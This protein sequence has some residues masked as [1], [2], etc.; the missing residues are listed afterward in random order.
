[1]EIELLTQT[2][3]SVTVEYTYDPGEPHQ[4]YDSKP[5]SSHSGDD[6]GA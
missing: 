5:R 3:E 4:Y 2:G 1:M 6:I